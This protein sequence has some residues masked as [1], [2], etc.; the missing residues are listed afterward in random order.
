MS[1]AEAPH[2]R[3]WLSLLLALVPTGGVA[4]AEVE[5]LQEHPAWLLVLIP[6]YLALSMLFGIVGALFER[7][8]PRWVDYADARAR[9][10]FHKARGRYMEWVVYR[11]RDFDVKGLKTQGPF[12]LDLL[13]VY[14]DLRLAARPLHEATG[15]PLASPAGIAAP[16]NAF[17]P[18]VQAHERLAIL[19]A[20]GSGKTTLLRHAALTLAGPPSTRKG[21]SAPAR[22]PILL[23]LREIAPLIAV[24][25]HSLATVA[26]TCAPKELPIDAE[27]LTNELRARRCLVMLDGLDEIADPASRDRVTQWVEAQVATFPGN[28]VVVSS[29]PFGYQTNPLSG[30]TVMEVQPL[31]RRQIEDFLH[32]WYLANAIKAT[33][34]DDPGVRIDAARDATDLMVRLDRSPDLVR[35]AVNPLLL[36]LIANV[37][38]Y[39]SMLPGRRVELYHEIGEV[40]LGKRQ[41]ARGIHLDLTPAQKTLVLQ[42]LAWHLM[43]TRRREIREDEA[44]EVIKEPLARVSPDITPSTFFRSVE[45]GSGLL[46]ERELGSWA[47][48]HKTFQEYLASVYAHEKGLGTRLAAEIHD[49]WWHETIRLYVAQGDA[50]EIVKACVAREPPE[51]ASLVLAV[52]C[53]D[54]AR[55]VSPATRDEIQQRVAL[56]MESEDPDRRRLAASCRL[57]LRLKNLQRIDDHTFA[58]VSLVTNAEYQLFIDAEFAAGRVRVPDHW[59]ESRFA[60]GT[61]TDPVLGVRGV[62]AIAFCEWLTHRDGGDWILRPPSIEE[63][64]DSLQDR[65]DLVFWIRRFMG[66]LDCISTPSGLAGPKAVERFEARVAEDLAW[67]DGLTNEER[68]RLGITIDADDIQRLKMLHEWAVGGDLRVVI[69]LSRRMLKRLDE[70]IWWR[71]AMQILDAFQDATSTA[72]A[73]SSKVVAWLNRALWSMYRDMDAAERRLRDEEQDEQNDGKPSKRPIPTVVIRIFVKELKLLSWLLGPFLRRQFGRLIAEERQRISRERQLPL[74]ESSPSLDR[75]LL[76]GDSSIDSALMGATDFSLML[77]L[78]VIVD[79]ILTEEG[80]LSLSG[81]GVA[82]LCDWTGCP[83]A[84]RAPSEVLA[85]RT[86]RQGGEGSH[87]TLREAASAVRVGVLLGW[88]SAVTSL[89]KGMAT[90]GEHAPA[91][92]DGEDEIMITVRAWVDAWQIQARGDGVESPFEGILLVKERRHSD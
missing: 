64:I 47:F 19:G 16:E 28:I 85:R 68:E 1:S 27:W 5:Y 6:A 56:E 71:V 78:Q 51:L 65:N 8:A 25:E 88:R 54:E 58:D 73:A 23:F 24:D 76:R 41:Q 63:T 81:D 18:A 57:D 37:H 34:R 72:F 80:Q 30:F 91:P 84:L 67:L 29:R 77:I 20:P 7:W 9:A 45:Q 13:A 43:V 38:R 82:R 40:F 70:E 46:L 42:H 52:Q 75:I 36:T 59:T 60:P 12:T 62:D 89:V 61:A 2:Q 3:W 32:R 33:Q 35:L 48:A 21:M 90:V 31:R 55:E 49:D 79:L 39:R 4:W 66:E 86:W 92:A 74:P 44:A 17:W 26:A 14:V 50:T 83:E 87:L 11:Y 69:S 22:T 53:V 15:D 10:W